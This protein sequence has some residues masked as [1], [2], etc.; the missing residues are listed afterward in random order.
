[1]L[2]LLT[3]RLHLRPHTLLNA[4]KLNAWENDPELLYYNDDQPD[5]RLPDPLADT[6][7]FIER[8]TDPRPEST[9]Y[10]YAIHTRDDGRLIGYGMIA[11]IDRYNRRCKLG[12]VI[13]EKEEWGKGYAREALAA[14]IKYCF[15]TLR[16]N[17]L[18][19]EIHAFNERSIRLFE[20]LGFCR[21]GTLRQVVR[22]SGAF[23]DEHIYGLLAQEWKGDRS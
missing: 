13:G 9:V 5:E 6:R 11:F 3:T 19:A 18:Q 2:S 7:Q 12:I 15:N 10:H 21:E 20:G 8:A 14:V 1:M 17:H 16:M 4:E 23:F 22:K